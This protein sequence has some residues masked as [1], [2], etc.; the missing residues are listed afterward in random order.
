M[1]ADRFPLM[2]QTVLDSL[3]GLVYWSIGIIG[4]VSIYLPFYPT[5]ADIEA[6]MEAWFET[7]PEAVVEGM[8]WHDIVSGP[9]YLNYT[10]Y[11]LF[12]PI[13][14]LILAIVYGNRFM[15]GDE[16]RGIFDIY[17]AYPL[18]RTNLLLE[19]FAAL[20]VCLIIIGI[21]VGLTVTIYVVALDMGVGLLNILAA[22]TG[23]TLLALLFGTLALTTGSATGQ[24][25]AVLGVAA[26]LAILSY[27]L[28]TLAP[29]V[30][31]LDWLRWLSPFHYALGWDPLREGFDLP[32]LSVVAAL[33]V[34]V[35]VIGAV[36]FE[37]RD[38]RT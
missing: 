30:E 37:R 8:G 25:G 7:L 13:L 17:L 11:G 18:G 15:A 1:I 29:M 4:I 26:G 12:G 16:D 24:P 28:D 22:T 32:M 36:L 27:A 23:L 19:R 35:L 20:A 34:A 5:M 9:G 2:T 10:V 33:I 14:M 21:V 3:R 38:I 31:G 6:G